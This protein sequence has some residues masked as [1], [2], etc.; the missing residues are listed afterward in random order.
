MGPKWGLNC[1]FVQLL[2]NFS[3]HA[4]EWLLNLDVTKYGV[5]EHEIALESM[6]NSVFVETIS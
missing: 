4:N 1:I 6:G 5:C 3:K 2:F